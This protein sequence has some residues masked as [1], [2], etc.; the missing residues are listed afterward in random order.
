M[1]QEQPSAQA[2][3]RPSAQAQ[4]RQLAQAMLGAKVL[5]MAQEKGP[6]GLLDTRVSKRQV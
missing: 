6:T 5:P 3:V 1:A 4:V 2:Q